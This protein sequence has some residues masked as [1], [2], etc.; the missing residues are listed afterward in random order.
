M[1]IFFMPNRYQLAFLASL[2]LTFTALLLTS[3]F[4]N[5]KLLAAGYDISELILIGLPKNTNPT[6]TAMGEVTVP[7]L[8]NLE[9]IKAH[10]QSLQEKIA[11]YLE[12]VQWKD[13]ASSP[14][15]ALTLAIITATF[16]Y[17]KIV[18]TGGFMR[19]GCD[20]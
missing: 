8:S 18:H 20:R 12:N 16:I 9:E 4:I 5:S 11:P 13:I 2:F 7:L 17:T 19:S 14:A 3:R 6:P 10:L 15:F 1:I